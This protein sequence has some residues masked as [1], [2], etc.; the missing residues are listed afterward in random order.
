MIRKS[1]WALLFAGSL[2]PVLAYASMSAHL[3][4]TLEVGTRGDQ[5]TVLQTL[6]A[7]DPAIYP[8]ASVTG[9]FGPLT[10]RA[11]KRFQARAGLDQVG[12]VGPLTLAKLNA[13]ADQ[14]ASAQ[15]SSAVA[16]SG[17]QSPSNA[18]PASLT[19]QCKNPWGS[20]PATIFWPT[21]LP[22]PAVTTTSVS[23]APTPVP[24]PTPTPVA[25]NPNN[26][27]VSLNADGTQKCAYTGS[28]QTFSWPATLS[29]PAAAAPTNPTPSPAIPTPV[30]VSFSPAP[31]PAPAKLQA[32]P[33]CLSSLGLSANSSQSELA[34]AAGKCG[35]A[36]LDPSLIDMSEKKMC[37]LNIL[38]KLYSF[39]YPSNRDC[40]PA[41]ITNATVTQGPPGFCNITYNGKT[42]PLAW[43]SNIPC[44]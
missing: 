10:T 13:F 34:N 8:E 12:R 26:S 16:A 27:N 24:A 37:S 31:S 15:T 39:P 40:P 29:C 7:A 28:T 38:G 25:G 17:G 43:P 36:V 19:T 32:M 6:L 44:K 2:I 5:V 41:P 1:I 3:T 30:P 9:F 14:L 4:G 33:T 42:T 35:G 11:V 21:G 18:S 22:C 20:S 23:P